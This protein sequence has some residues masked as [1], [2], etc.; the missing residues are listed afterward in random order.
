MS[1]TTLIRWR[2][3]WVEVAGGASVVSLVMLKQFSPWQSPPWGFAWAAV[4]SFLSML[5]IVDGFR[6]GCLADLWVVDLDADWLRVTCNGHIR[7]NHPLFEFRRVTIRGDKIVCEL[8]RA[9]QTFFE[10]FPLAVVTREQTN[11]LLELNPKPA[12]AA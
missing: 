1:K 11:R 7:M 8:N 12:G 3:W 9:G 10:S 5:V 4:F 6:R 2:F